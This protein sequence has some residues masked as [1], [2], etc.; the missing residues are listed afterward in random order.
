MIFMGFILYM[1]IIIVS[2]V[3]IGL[4]VA[5]KLFAPDNPLTTIIIAYLWPLFL[6]IALARKLIGK[7]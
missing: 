5:C 6:L 3:A 1:F 4:F 2:Y 7:D